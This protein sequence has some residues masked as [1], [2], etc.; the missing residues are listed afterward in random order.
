[1]TR[2]TKILGARPPKIPL[3]TP[4]GPALWV[5]PLATPMHLLKKLDNHSDTVQLAILKNFDGMSLGELLDFILRFL[6]RSW[7][8]WA[9]LG[10]RNNEFFKLM[11][12]KMPVGVKGWLY[13]C[14][15]GFPNFW[16]EIVYFFTLFFWFR[17]FKKLILLRFVFDCYY[18]IDKFSCLFISWLYF[19]KACL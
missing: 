6:M 12:E 4:M 11:F 2:Y 15:K 13:F 7:I 19:W 1:M 9:S 17:L 5:P 10:A 3:A 14:R 16:K 8:S 18:F